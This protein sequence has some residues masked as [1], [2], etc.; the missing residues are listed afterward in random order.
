M[1][2]YAICGGLSGLVSFYKKVALNVDIYVSNFFE[3]STVG[4]VEVGIRTAHLLFKEMLEQFFTSFSNL[5]TYLRS[6]SN[7]PIFLDA[8]LHTR[9]VHT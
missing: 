1:Y 5:L 6:A 9:Y 3:V 4:N 7:F 2:I 8:A